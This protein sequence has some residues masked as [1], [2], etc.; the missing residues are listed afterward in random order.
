MKTN[1][2]RGY[3]RYEN[4]LNNQANHKSTFREFVGKDE[5]RGLYKVRLGH[6][7]YAANHTLTRVY[8][9]NENNELTPVSQ[10]T[11]NTKEWILRNL[12]TEI[13]YRRG[14]E[15]GQILQKTHIPSPDRKAYK[16]RRGFL[17]TR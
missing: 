15:L 14:R 8:T 1:Y 2:L 4:S 11:L 9:V 5:E 3:K 10:Y 7:V 13:K 12:E 16:I 17:G 6:T